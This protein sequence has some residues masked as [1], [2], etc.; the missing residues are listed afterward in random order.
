MKDT[1]EVFDWSSV[2]WS[3]MLI[4]ARYDKDVILV[5]KDC[6]LYY[7]LQVSSLYKRLEHYINRLK[8]PSSTSSSII[9]TPD[10]NQFSNLITTL[11]SRPKVYEDCSNKDWILTCI[12]LP[13]LLRFLLLPLSNHSRS[14]ILH[15]YDPSSQ[16]FSSIHSL[17]RLSSLYNQLSSISSSQYKLSL[18]KQDFSNRSR[19][20]FTT[21]R[22]KKVLLEYD[23]ELDL[24]TEYDLSDSVQ[25][26]FYSTSVCL[27]PDGRLLLAGGGFTL[28]SPETYIIDVS[29]SPPASIRIGDLNFP[30]SCIKLIC[31][32]DTVFAFGGWDGRLDSKRAECLKWQKHTRWTPLPDMC[33]PRYDF[34]YFIRNE[35]IFI[36]GGSHNTT[37]EYYDLAR[38]RFFSL[39]IKVPYGGNNAVLYKD[40]VYLI[41]HSHINTYDKNLISLESKYFLDYE[42]FFAYNNFICSSNCV[43]RNESMYYIRSDVLKLYIC[44]LQ[45][46]SRAVFRSF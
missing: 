12:N 15:S 20:L 46:S 31:Y 10:L 43:I 26:S 8:S 42:F 33:R 11:L 23:A 41:D 14:K 6:R 29:Y 44:D 35:R 45:R 3:Q 2:D 22:N 34:G 27:L 40:K 21:I 5:S 39:D 18:L 32:R 30:R 36:L 37:V 9:F 38:N 4:G 17:S 24:S 28:A 16:A 25:T 7:L 19:F 13:S 1:V